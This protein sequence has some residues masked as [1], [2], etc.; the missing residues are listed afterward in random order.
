LPRCINP[1]GGLIASVNE[2][3]RYA[4]FHLGD[5]RAPDGRALLTPAGLA[6]M[7]QPLAIAGH[8]ADATGVSWMLRAVGGVPIIE[9]SGGTHGQTTR[10]TL[11]PE[12]DFAVIVLTNDGRGAALHGELCAWVLTHFLGLSEPTPT[13]LQLPAEQLGQYVGRYQALLSTVVV[14][15]AADGLVVEV[16]P[17]GNFPLRGF[18]AGP[19]PA[20][21]A[22]AFFAVDR[23][24][25]ID[26]EQAG[27]RG[28]FLR[29]DDGRIA[30]LRFGGR[31][32][33]RQP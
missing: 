22:A 13:W 12:R 9:H 3:L 31:I 8:A 25:L 4:R 2:L 1:I 10:L 21:A 15:Q 16:I 33:A 24:S 5:G 18:P 30:W 27:S 7:R 20:P 28:E 26:G 17:N 14:S 23:L 29:G 11:V 32:H 6:R 19:A